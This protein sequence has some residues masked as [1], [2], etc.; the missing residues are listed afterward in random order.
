MLVVI[1]YVFYTL[2]IYVHSV[3]NI[4][5]TNKTEQSKYKS[6]LLSTT[7]LFI[8][9]YVE[10]FIESHLTFSLKITVEQNTNSELLPF[11]KADKKH[12]YFQP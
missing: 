8:I 11:N 4:L 3:V 1:L 7:T 10:E 9:H 12:V 2:V 5:T 6:N